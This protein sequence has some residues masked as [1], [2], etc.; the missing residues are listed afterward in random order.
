ML[1]GY[2]ASRFRF[3][4]GRF[5]KLMILIMAMIP[6]STLLAPAFVMLNDLGLVNS[7]IAIIGILVSPQTIRF[8]KKFIDGLPKE[9]EQAAFIDGA[10]RLRITKASSCCSSC[11]VSRPPSFSA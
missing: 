2:A 6:A 1:A 4:A 8:L 10:S 9:L 3:M 7:P 11:Q 5:A